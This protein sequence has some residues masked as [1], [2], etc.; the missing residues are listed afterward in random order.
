MNFG[1]S[2]LSPGEFLTK[3]SSTDQDSKMNSDITYNISNNDAFTIDPTTGIISAK[4]FPTKS[5]YRLTIT[6]EDN[7]AP[8]SATEKNVTVTF[9]K[10]SSSRS[11]TD[12][13]S[14]SFTFIRS[15]SSTQNERPEKPSYTFKF[16]NPATDPGNIAHNMPA[17]LAIGSFMS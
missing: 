5:D 7:G 8:S 17:S 11:H 14:T 10:T 6:A 3:I 16:T 1:L 13:F 2:S 4:S 12:A 9:G 15:K